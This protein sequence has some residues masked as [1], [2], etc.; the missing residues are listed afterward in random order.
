[1]HLAKLG[2]LSLW[3]CVLAACAP[4]VS[5]ESLAATAQHFAATGVAQT[6]TAAPTHTPLP[7]AIPSDTPTPTPSASPSE[8][9]N[10][11]TE[12]PAAQLQGTLINLLPTPVSGTAQ[13]D[14]Q[15]NQTPLLLQN[16]SSQ[17]IWLIIE[18]STYFEYRFSD[19]ML[20]LLPEGEYHYT[21]YIGQKGPFEG[22]FDLRN[23]DKHTLIFSAGKVT[24]QKP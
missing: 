17:N 11:P 6:L 3:L 5:A 1:M 13:S 24:F 2:L 23:E 8:T 9:P 10:L 21:A 18:G 7:T 14:K 16:N 15:D 20:I 22:N 12:T 4:A 19:T